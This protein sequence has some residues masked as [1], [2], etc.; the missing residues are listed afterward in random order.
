MGIARTLA[1]RNAIVTGGSRGIGAGIALE[2][3]KLGANVLITYEKATQAAEETVRL[4]KDFGVDAI[5]LQASGLE[6]ES[7]EKIVKAVVE[8]W[9]KVDIIVNNAGIGDDILLQDLSED[10]LDRHLAINLKM[11]IF[12]TKAAIPHF[13]QA[14][15]I[16]NVSS[17]S[18]RMGG[19]YGTAYC[20]SKAALEGATKVLAVEIGQKYNA[21]VNCV[22][23][24]PVDTDLWRR[25]APEVRQ[26]WE[27]EKA[28]DT[29][30]AARIGTVDDVAQIVMFLCHEQSR[31]CT[32][33]TI[34]ANGGML[35][36]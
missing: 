12:L 2:L 21:T 26:Y 18:A 28:K 7:P 16:V 15:R 25:T 32:G 11:P 3:G 36:V 4:I 22:N 31:W 30:A 6:A 1:G 27:T 19:E 29:P 33:S 20:A 8:K 35:F 23:P 34:C 5:A 14:P 9:G 13:G 17:V 10:E 24:G